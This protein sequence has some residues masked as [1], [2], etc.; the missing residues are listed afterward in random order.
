M[1]EER[2]LSG[3]EIRI[4][5]SDKI[6]EGTDDSGRRYTQIFQKGGL[7]IF[8]VMPTSSSNGIWDVRG[9]QFCSQWPPST[10]WTCYDM[11]AT[12]TV[13]KFIAPDGKIWPV[14]IL[15]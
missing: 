2:K 10:F 9:D 3:V 12:G 7:T 1:A 8:N 13:L 11:M 15:D 6:V 5:L 14:T 4:A